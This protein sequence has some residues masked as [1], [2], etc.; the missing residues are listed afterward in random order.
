MYTFKQQCPNQLL[1]YTPH[2][3]RGYMKLMLRILSLPFSSAVH[4]EAARVAFEL[5]LLKVSIATAFAYSRNES[6][7]LY[8]DSRVHN[9]VDVHAWGGATKIVT[10]LQ[11]YRLSSSA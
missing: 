6:T 11:M 8:L 1:Q 4:V 7:I 10:S 3:L 9:S 5:L 2:N